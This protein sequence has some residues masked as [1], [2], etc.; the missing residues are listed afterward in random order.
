VFAACGQLVRV[1]DC[2]SLGRLDTV[3][4]HGRTLER[5]LG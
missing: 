3:E 5:L 4:D 1:L 2:W